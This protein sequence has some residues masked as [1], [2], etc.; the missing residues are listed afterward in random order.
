[1]NSN[2]IARDLG[3]KDSVSNEHTGANGG[4]IKHEITETAADKFA[5][6]LNDLTE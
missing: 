5:S 6:I 2:I 4:A 1:L 3:L